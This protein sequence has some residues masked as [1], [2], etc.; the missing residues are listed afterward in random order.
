M[1]TQ[2][3]PNVL[4]GFTEYLNSRL[5]LHQNV[6]RAGRLGQRSLTIW[7]RGGSV[8]RLTGGLPYA[9][10]CIC[11]PRLLPPPPPHQHSTCPRGVAQTKIPVRVTRST[12]R[13]NDRLMQGLS[14]QVRTVLEQQVAGFKASLAFKDSPGNPV[15]RSPER[16]PQ[17]GF[18][19]R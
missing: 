11:Q 13:L 14:H 3:Q 5:M 12:N 16:V 1:F 9:L 8:E 10:I 19:I 18:G 15:D 4:C 6:M 2:P 17:F 7:L